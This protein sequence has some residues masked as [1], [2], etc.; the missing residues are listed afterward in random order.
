[1]DKQIIKD[2]ELGEKITQACFLLNATLFALE[3][4]QSTRLFKHSLKNKIKGLNE[5]LE[6]FL[7]V[8]METAFQ[9]NPGSY[10]K[11]LNGLSNIAKTIS[12]LSVFQI[13]EAEKAINQVKDKQFPN[14]NEKSC[15]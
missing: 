3:E 2:K 9:S 10:D 11:M 6:V 1:M 12:Q 15:S 7:K 14:E 8:P 13:E 4:L 5:E